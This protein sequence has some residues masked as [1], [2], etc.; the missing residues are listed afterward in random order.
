[1]SHHRLAA[2]ML[3]ALAGQL[4]AQTGTPDQQSPRAGAWYNVG[5]SFLV[6]QQQIR[7]GVAGTLEGIVLTLNGPQGSQMDVRIRLGDGPSVNPVLFSTQLTKA[8]PDDEVVFVN[9][10]ASAIALT[11]GQTFVMETQ[12]NDTMC[13][14]IG[15]Y[16]DPAMGPP[17]YPEPL[18]LGGTA[19]PAGW[20]HGFTSYMITGGPAPCYAN[21]DASTTPPV[22][23]VSDFV[24]FLNAFAAG[25]PS[26]NCDN[27][28]TPP[29][30]NI[31]DFV[32][33]LGRFTAGCS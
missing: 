19:F 6:W 17:L 27:S 23:N 4:Q 5:P 25:D 15:N 12:G 33:F 30:L 21:C 7:A 10:Q 2:T 18:F 8:T 28:T 16:V 22:L 3:L 31:L 26:A 11:A 14:L 29:T 32:C 1:M 13:G 24:C 9:M 20:R